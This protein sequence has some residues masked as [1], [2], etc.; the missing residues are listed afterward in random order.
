MLSSARRRQEQLEDID[1]SFASDA[2]TRPATGLT[3]ASSFSRAGTPPPPVL[4]G[5]VSSFP[6]Y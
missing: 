5:H 4:T 3:T 2:P 6:P 1:A